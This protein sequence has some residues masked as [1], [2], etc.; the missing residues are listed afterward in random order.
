MITLYD[1]V[2]V[3]SDNN[4]FNCLDDKS[5]SLLNKV[6]IVENISDKMY[7]IDF[8]KDF[9]GHLGDYSVNYG[10]GH[11]WWMPKD[12]VFKVEDSSIDKLKNMSNEIN[13]IKSFNFNKGCLSSNEYYKLMSSIKKISTCVIES[14]GGFIGEDG[15]DFK[16]I[17]LILS[18]EEL[19]KSLD[20]L[21]EFYNSLINN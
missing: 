2:I 13:T 18:P 21:N 3:L 19:K 11:L 4:I 9:K 6:G 5:K 16:S 7:L 10:E 12:C 8:G 17:G 14:S 1:K 15:T 20:V